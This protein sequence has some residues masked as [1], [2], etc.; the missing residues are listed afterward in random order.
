MTDIEQ[1]TTTNTNPKKGKFTEQQ[2]IDALIA[3]KGM[4]TKAAKKL[5]CE[6]RTIVRYINEY[7][8]VAEAETLARETM[9]DA[10]E[11]KAYSQAM[12][13]DTTMIIFMLKTQGKS[14]GYV[15]RTEHTGAGGGAIKTE[16]K[17]T[18]LSELS[19][20]ELDDYI[21]GK[22]PRSEGRESPPGDTA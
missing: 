17:V 5:R 2:V 14:R 6:Y 3:T 15:D 22:H 10:V 18:L 9:L 8:A 7:P 20:E 16:S 4:R 19:D 21:A 1:E 11:L 13:G 12:K